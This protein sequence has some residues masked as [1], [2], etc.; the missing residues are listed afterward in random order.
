LTLWRQGIVDALEIVNAERHAMQTQLEG[1]CLAWE[2]ANI[3]LC[4][5]RGQL[6]G[7]N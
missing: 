5:I 4:L 6:V 3:E 7:L 1:V 2:A